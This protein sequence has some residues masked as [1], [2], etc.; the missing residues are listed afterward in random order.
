[1]FAGGSGIAPFRG[2]WQA[3]VAQRSGRN[4]IFLGV[5]SREKLLYEGEIRDYVQQGKL[6]PHVAFSRDRNGLQYIPFT[7]E[8]VE[9]SIE[10]RYIDSVI[11]E[12]GRT[13]Y[14]MIMPKESGGLGGYLYVCGSISPYE[15]VM[16]GIRQAMYNCRNVTKSQAE[17]LVAMAFAQRRFMLGKRSIFLP[18]VSTLR[19]SSHQMCKF[20]SLMAFRYIYDAPAVLIQAGIDIHRPTGQKYRA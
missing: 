16:C 4:I 15:T 20:Q 14:D 1:M 19:F 10:P 9:K 7:K 17:E 6:E 11:I 8:L 5:Q 18:N 12:Q 2:F 3:R 13:I